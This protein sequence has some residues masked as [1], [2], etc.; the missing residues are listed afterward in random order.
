VVR[1][2]TTVLN[3][4]YNQCKDNECWCNKPEVSS[5]HVTAKVLEPLP[6]H[7]D[8]AYHDQFSMYQTVGAKNE[9]FVMYHE[10][11]VDGE[12]R[13]ESLVLY[14]TPTGE[15]IEVSIDTKWI[16]NPAFS[17]ESAEGRVQRHA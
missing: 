11:Y 15:R 17:R 10:N 6:P 13:I 1:K 3:N 16:N 8:P 7:T 2:V 5:G 14:H 4:N 12:L 9:V